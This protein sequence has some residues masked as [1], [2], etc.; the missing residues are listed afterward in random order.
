VDCYREL[1]R[2]SQTYKGYS[3]KALTLLRDALP[4]INIDEIWEK[5]RSKLTNSQ[6]KVKLA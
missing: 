6:A 5:H 2:K 3:L 1:K 4:K